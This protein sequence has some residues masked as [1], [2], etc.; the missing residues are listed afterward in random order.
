M[1]THDNLIDAIDDRVNQAKAAWGKI[2]N[3][4]IKNKNIDGELRIVLFASLIA[5]ILLRFIHIG[6]IKK[7]YIKI[8]MNLF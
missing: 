3:S 6:P 2:R 1:N 8:A 4:F 7:T 5:S